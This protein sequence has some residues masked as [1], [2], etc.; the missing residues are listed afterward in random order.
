MATLQIR[1]ISS[2]MLTF[3]AYDMHYAFGKSAIKKG[4]GHFLR[5]RPFKRDNFTSFIK[6]SLDLRPD[7]QARSSFDTQED[8]IKD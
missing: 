7:L 5:G 6:V 2:Q 1:Q 4:G 3:Q 8:L